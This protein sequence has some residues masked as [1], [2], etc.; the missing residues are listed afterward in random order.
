MKIAHIIIADSYREGWGYQQ[1]ILPVKHM[2]LGYKVYIIAKPVS[3]HSL[4][5]EEYVNKDGL[6]VSILNSN[7][8]RKTTPVINLFYNITIG[9][10]CKLEEIAP[11][12]IFIHGLQAIDNLAVCKYKKKHPDV[13]VYVDQHGD[14]YNMPITSLKNRLIQKLFFKRIAKRLEKISEKMWGVTPWRVHYLQNVYNISPDKTGLLVMGGDEKLIDWEHKDAIR[15]KI[16]KAHNIPEDAFLII[17]GGKI[18]R[19]KN[20]HLLI[21]AFNKMGREDVHLVIF[22]NYNEE[23]ERVCKP[24]FNERITDIG[25]VNSNDVYPYFLAADLAVFPGTHSVLWEQVCAAGLP[26]IFKD[27]NGGMNHVDVG[28][29]CVLL[30]DITVDIIKETILNILENKNVYSKMKDI[31]ET[32]GRNTFSYIEIAK[33]SIG[34]I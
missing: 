21:E 34:M 3:G 26:A 18:D 8:S 32:T 30:N 28:G 13:K 7:K 9:L 4:G 5:G 27:W 25:W 12:V 22:G 24:M 17:T 19:V 15:T 6:N 11:D 10:Y 29:N 16:R 23:M 1:N 14:Y 2:E 33:K 31:A 20:I